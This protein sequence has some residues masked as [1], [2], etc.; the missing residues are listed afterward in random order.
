MNDKNEENQELQN[1]NENNQSD[2]NNLKR[3][4]SPNLGENESNKI[5]DKDESISESTKLKVDSNIK[6]EKGNN[7]FYHDKDITEDSIVYFSNKLKTCNKNYKCIL[8]ISIIIYIIDIFIWFSSIENLNSYQNI[9]ILLIILI[10]SIHQIIS[11]R[12]NFESI[13]KNLYIFTKQIMYAFC[14]IFIVYTIN[15]LYIFIN[16]IIDMNKVQ[17]YLVDKTSENIFVICYCIVNIFISGFQLFR[18]VSVK[19]A[20]KDLSSAKGEVYESGKIE[21]VEIINSVI[22]EI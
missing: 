14:F 22:N 1:N 9:L 15:I 8:S 17:Y 16:R 10:S 11:F 3:E 18:L 7:D 5:V 20:I 13:S 12:H 6:K 21:E 2:D 19:K 4:D